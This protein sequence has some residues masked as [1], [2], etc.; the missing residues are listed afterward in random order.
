MSK[1]KNKQSY[2]QLENFYALNLKI[3]TTSISVK[4]LV[5]VFI[6]YTSKVLNICNALKDFPI[7]FRAYISLQVHTILQFLQPKGQA[8]NQN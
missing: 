7:S 4:D 2:S 1:Y 3:N 8:P 6:N 5:W